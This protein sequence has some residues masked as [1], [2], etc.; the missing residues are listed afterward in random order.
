MNYK[1]IESAIRLSLLGAGCTKEY[2]DKQTEEIIKIIKI[3][4][5]GD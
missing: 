1:K 4:E 5:K 3:E 2:G